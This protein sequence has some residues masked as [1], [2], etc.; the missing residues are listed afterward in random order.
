MIEEMKENST[1]NWLVKIIHSAYSERWCVNTSCTTC[2][3]LE[4]RSAIVRGA[5]E[6]AKQDTSQYTP[7]RSGR[8]LK[9]MLRDLP[10]E[11]RAG[12]INEITSALRGIKDTS[13][14]WDALKLLLMDLDDHYIMDA[15]EQSLDD[16][17]EGT[18]VG[19]MLASMRNHYAN[20]IAE[21]RQRK[22][23]EQQ[24]KKLKYERTL[25]TY[26]CQCAVAEAK[27][28][29]WPPLPNRIANATKFNTDE[30]LRDF[31]SG[32]KAFQD[33]LNDRK[34]LPLFQR[35]PKR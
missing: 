24:N 31:V 17:L 33:H 15:S 23:V 2:G 35:T 22:E 27:G 30:E 11:K 18:A 26:L 19:E 20:L 34:D 10:P 12:A 5:M 25:D 29:S 9:P 4:Y 14:M 1:E 8:L 7:N 13:S 28:R 3:A 32:H 16:I 21:R 6:A